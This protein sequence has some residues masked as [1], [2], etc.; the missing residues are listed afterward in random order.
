ML[1][2]CYGDVNMIACDSIKL[3][4]DDF[5]SLGK[6]GKEYAIIFVYNNIDNA[7]DLHK[8]ECVYPIELQM[9]EQSFKKIAQFVYSFHSEIAFIKA[10]DQIRVKHRHI[11]VYSMA[12]NIEGIGRRALIPLICKYYNI[13]NIG[14]DEYASFLSGDKKLMQKLLENNSELH[15]PKTIYI[16]KYKTKSL[17]DLIAQMHAG[18][19]I[20]KPNNESAS[21][22]VKQFELC[23]GNSKQVYTD[24]L[25]YSKNYSNYC[26][27]EYID[28]LEVEVPIIKIGQDYFCPGVCQIIFDDNINYLDYDTVGVDSYDFTHYPHSDTKIISDAVRVAKNLQFN[29]ISRI[30]FRVKDGIP[31][32]IDIGANPTISTHSSTNYLFRNLLGNEASVYHILVIRAL[33]QAGLFKPSFDQTKQ[34]W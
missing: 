21:I 33:L 29:C 19:Y 24:L 16:N 30:D 3:L 12:Q 27:Q 17:I 23:S 22:G 18:Q 9:I 31:Y 25:E 14:S 5:C 34:N 26:I 8:T 4:Y 20:V 13:I 2:W 10:V 28:G 7:D 32:I 1:R 15:F 11:L 6:L